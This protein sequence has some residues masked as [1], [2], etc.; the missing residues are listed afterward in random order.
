[1][2]YKF[3]NKEIDIPDK[4][5]EVLVD[6]LDLSLEEAIE[7]WLVDNDY[8]IDE[9]VERLT[10]MAKEN[11]SV[12]HDAKSDKPRAKRTVVQKENPVKENIINII[13]EALRK[14]GV[15]AAITNKTKII[16]FTVEGRKFKIDL[17]EHRTKKGGK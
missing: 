1:M 10:K 16:E 15:V 12:K 3:K 17:V 8:E 13:A 11:K 7:T 2:K 9:E 14:E 5:I 6:T 4:E